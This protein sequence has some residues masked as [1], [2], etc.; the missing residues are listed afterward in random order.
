MFVSLRY[1]EIEADRQLYHYGQHLQHQQQQYSTDWTAST[2]DSYTQH[3]AYP[4]QPVSTSAVYSDYCDA[5][6]P[7]C[8][9]YQPR[10][11]N[12]AST[13]H[14]H[15]VSSWNLQSVSH[16]VSRPTRETFR[17]I[18]LRVCV[19]YIRQWNEVNWRRL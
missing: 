17:K 9:W 18:P 4:S 15:D 8:S 16:D 7:T 3:C 14:G 5:V 13:L 11:H 1:N 6:L 10:G 2:Y 19:Y 12:T